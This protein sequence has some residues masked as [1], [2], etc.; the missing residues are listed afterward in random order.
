MCIALQ[1]VAMTPH[2]HHVDS[3]AFCIDCV[4]LC[5]STSCDDSDHDTVPGDHEPISCSPLEM[6]LTVQELSVFKSQI[7]C[8]DHHMHCAHCTCLPCNVQTAALLDDSKASIIICG[9]NYNYV[10][11]LYVTHVLSAIPPRAPDFLS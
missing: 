2:H 10:S 5:E 1:S 11:S 7:S 9:N 8:T 4:H 3:L 6:L